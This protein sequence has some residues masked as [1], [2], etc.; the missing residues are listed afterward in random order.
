MYKVP[1]FFVYLYTFYDQCFSISGLTALHVFGYWGSGG[2]WSPVRG[3]QSSVN[4][5]LTLIVGKLTQHPSG[6][7]SS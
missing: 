4:M 1:I 6:N 3:F 2:G 7:V 5:T